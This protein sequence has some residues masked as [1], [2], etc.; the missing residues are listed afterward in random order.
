[1]PGTDNTKMN[2]SWRSYSPEAVREEKHV[3]KKSGI[4]VVSTILEI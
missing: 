4:N 3:K 1:M 2:R